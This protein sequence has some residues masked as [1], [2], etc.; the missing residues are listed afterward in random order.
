M[1]FAPLQSKL[2]R[3]A[4]IIARAKLAQEE[5]AEAIENNSSLLV[6]G[7]ISLINRI[8]SRLKTLFRASSPSA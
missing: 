4:E 7:K 1:I 6:T 3:E 2:E 8:L 5:G